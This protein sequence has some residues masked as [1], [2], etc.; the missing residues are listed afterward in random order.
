MDELSYLSRPARRSQSTLLGD[1]HGLNRQFLSLLLSDD[2]P[3][4]TAGL[5]DCVRATLGSLNDMALERLATCPYSLFDVR[6]GQADIWRDVLA[7]D[8]AT[9]APDQTVAVSPSAGAFVL[10]TLLYTRQICQHHDDM[11][12]LLLGMTEETVQLLGSQPLGKLTNCAFGGRP[13]LTARLHN[14]PHFWPDL[15]DFVRDGTRERS[16]AAHTLGMQHAAAKF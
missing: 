2:Q 9:A 15:I 7:S 11:A 16:L 13:A 1:L 10:A 8:A 6:F 4:T 3:E 14:H 5:D 12:R